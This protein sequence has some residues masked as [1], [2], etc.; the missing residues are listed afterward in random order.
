MYGVKWRNF[1][2]ALVEQKFSTEPVGKLSAQRIINLVTDPQERENIALPYLHS[3][4]AIHFNKLIA[5]F[6]TSIRGEPPIPAGA[7]LEFVPSAKSV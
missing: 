5:E 1:K 6:R 7:P 3:W 4:T 2:L